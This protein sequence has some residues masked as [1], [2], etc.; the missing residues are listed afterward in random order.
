MAKFCSKCGFE[1]NDGESVCLSC[2]HKEKSVSSSENEKES[3]P[4]V[5]MWSYVG[6]TLLFSLGLIGLIFCIVYACNHHNQ[7]IKNYARANLV[8][9]GILTLVSIIL[10]ALVLPLYIEL[11]EELL[12]GM[13][14][15][16]IY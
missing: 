7:N 12:S 9:L 6:Y 8:V 3:A 13:E 14:Q 10:M 1:M 4:V 11:I 16:G 5:G 15:G 2:G